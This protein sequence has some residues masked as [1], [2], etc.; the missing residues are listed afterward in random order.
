MTLL[1]RNQLKAMLDY[2]VT[3]KLFGTIFGE[4]V[5]PKTQKH[6]IFDDSFNP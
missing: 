3:S 4:R 2:E 1:L 5:N 6:S